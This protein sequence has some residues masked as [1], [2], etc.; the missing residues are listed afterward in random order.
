MSEAVL[1]G[2][3]PD[4]GR[5]FEVPRVTVLL[6]ESDPTVL[7]LAFS[8]S[9]ELDRDNATQVEHYNRLRAGQE[10]ELVVTAR[11]AGTQKGHRLDSEGDLADIVESKRLVVSEVY[12]HEGEAEA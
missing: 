1:E 2:Q 3:S 4:T 10:V 12:L 8:G 7:K 5:L 11:V 9:Y 6:D